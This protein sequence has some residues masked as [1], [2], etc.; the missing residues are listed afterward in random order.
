M[1][2]FDCYR[3]VVSD[4]ADYTKSFVRIADSRV[5]RQVEEEM[6]CGLLWPEPLLQLNP[7]FQ[8]GRSIDELVAEQDLHQDCGRIFRVKANDNDF[9][10]PIRLDRH[11]CQGTFLPQTPPPPKPRAW[12]SPFPFRCSAGVSQLS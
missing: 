12:S 9:G 10:H 3:H 8:P 7:A 5:A 2:V 1:D 4:Y 6:G 11:Q